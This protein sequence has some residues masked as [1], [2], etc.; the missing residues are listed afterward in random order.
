M[1][2]WGIQLEDNF[3]VEEHYHVNFTGRVIAD[4]TNNT[5]EWKLQWKVKEEGLVG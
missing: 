5:E 1:A 4:H 3:T 2:Q